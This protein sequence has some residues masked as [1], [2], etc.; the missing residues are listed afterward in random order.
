LLHERL[1]DDRFVAFSRSYNEGH[2]FARAF[3]TQVNLGCEAT[4]T[5]T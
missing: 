2:G 1:E 4:A 5:A 3:S